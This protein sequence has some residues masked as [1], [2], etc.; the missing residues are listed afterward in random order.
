MSAIHKP[1][2]KMTEFE[3]RDILIRDLEILPDLLQ[4]RATTDM[5][6]VKVY[7]DAMT[8]GSFFPPVIVFLTP[9]GR[10]LL[11]DGF[12][13]VEARVRLKLKNVRCVIRP[14]VIQDAILFGIENNLSVD[15]IR[16]VTHA[17]R[18]HAA[19]LMIRNEEFRSWSD[20]EIGRHCGISG[21]TVRKVRLSLTETEGIALPEKIKKFSNGKPM[22]KMAP[23]L[24]RLLPKRVD[25][26]NNLKLTLASTLGFSGWLAGRAIHSQTAG[27]YGIG[28]L[29]VGDAFVVPVP[30]ADFSA[31]LRAVGI[32][33]LSR[34][35]WNEPRRVILVGYFGNLDH[36]GA[37]A[38][39]LAHQL[40]E[41]I[42]FM[43]PE[44]F[45]TAFGGTPDP[46][47]DPDAQTEKEGD[48]SSESAL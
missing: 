22:S 27:H 26:Q 41:P 37:K 35:Q 23:Y 13:R 9:E 24:A 19:K 14:G 44:E 25:R 43:T 17:D 1:V 2:T 10:F 29:F 5:R 20:S 39:S 47:T 15:N 21:I 36:R 48:D 8:T 18:T 11:A 33:V 32:A 6:V 3:Q 4:T 45:S 34:S 28:G 7:S 12:H 40:P 30:D 38:V 31:I 16:E 46:S 42:R